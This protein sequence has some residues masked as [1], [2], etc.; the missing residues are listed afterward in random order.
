[1]FYAIMLLGSAGFASY[2]ANVQDWKQFAMCSV[3]VFVNGVFFLRDA[4]EAK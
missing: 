4:L 1:M 2:F 3:S